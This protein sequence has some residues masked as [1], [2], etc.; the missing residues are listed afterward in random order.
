MIQMLVDSLLT[1]RALTATTTV[2]AV[3]KD[4]PIAAKRIAG[5][6][7]FMQHLGPPNIGASCIPIPEFLITK[8]TRGA[9]ELIGDSPSCSLALRQQVDYWDDIVF[10]DVVLLL[11]SFMYA[12]HP[13]LRWHKRFQSPHRRLACMYVFEPIALKPVWCGP[14]SC[15]SPQ[16]NPSA[17]VSF[18]RFRPHHKLLSIKH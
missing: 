9:L 2:L 8:N 18:V 4:S 17:V 3:C 6:L 14:N 15:C 12:V 7:I 11:F 13:C 16:V 10:A 5:T 1:C